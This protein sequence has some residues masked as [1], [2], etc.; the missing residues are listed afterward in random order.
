MDNMSVETKNRKD[1]NSCL[2]FILIYL[3]SRSY[4]YC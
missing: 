1:K 4:N 3:K 2:K